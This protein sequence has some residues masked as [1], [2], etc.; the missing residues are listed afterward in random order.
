MRVG[1]TIDIRANV[2]YFV[3]PKHRGRPSENSCTWTISVSDE[4][5]LFRRAL[6]NVCYLGQSYWAAE[7]QGNR[8]R[9]VGINV[10]GETLIFGKFIDGNAKAIWHGYPA[11]YRRHPQDRPPI[12]SAKQIIMFYPIL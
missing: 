9:T 3:H 5:A 6:P 1:S 11:D 10:H 4:V 2:Q 7:A 12:A 8:L